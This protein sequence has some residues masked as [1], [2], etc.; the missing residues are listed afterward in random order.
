M[1]FYQDMQ[2]LA[3][4][5]LGEFDQGDI[6]LIKVASGTGPDWNPGDPTEV[7]HLVDGAI[8]GV[9]EKYVDG[10]LVVASDLQCVIPGGGQVPTTS[11]VIRSGGTRYQIVQVIPIPAAG[12]AAA[13]DVIIRK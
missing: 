10:S 9:S 5:V 12:I 3:K 6:Y 8:A 7:P 11:D 2:D 1:T 4:D 13:Y